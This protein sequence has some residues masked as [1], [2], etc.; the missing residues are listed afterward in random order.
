MPPAPLPHSVG[1]VGSTGIPRSEN[2]ITGRPLPSTGKVVPFT[3][4]SATVAARS[5]RL[6]TP[7][8]EAAEVV[9]LPLPE[10]P[11]KLLASLEASSPEPDEA[12]PLPELPLPVT[13]PTTPATVSPSAPTV[14]A[15]AD[16]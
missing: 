10:L 13:P 2:A 5:A 12:L 16:A 1:L 8:V 4:V 7:V 3:T 14:P 9:L 15:A 6:A 11:D